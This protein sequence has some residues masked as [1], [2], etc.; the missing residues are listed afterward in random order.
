MST[1]EGIKRNGFG[2]FLISSLKN[3]GR[4]AVRLFFAPTLAIAS[5]AKKS[6][7]RLTAMTA[8]PKNRKRKVKSVE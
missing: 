3:D 8:K 1:R 5:E 7:N 2:E 4:Q 6:M